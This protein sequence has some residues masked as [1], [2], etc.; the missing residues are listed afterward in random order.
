[1]FED[2]MDSRWAESVKMMGINP[3]LLSNTP[4]HA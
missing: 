4:G 3:M 2:A 1:M